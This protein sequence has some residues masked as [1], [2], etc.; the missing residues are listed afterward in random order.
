MMNKFSI[1]SSSLYLSLLS[2]FTWAETSTEV[3]Q[4]IQLQAETEGENLQQSTAMTK[5]SHDILDV[6]FSRSVLSKALI[7]QQDVQRI[8]DALT[9][10][11]GVYSQTNYGGGFWDNFSF[12]GFSTDPNI[13][14]QII[15][16]GLSVNRGLSAPRDMVNIESLDFLKGPMA[17]LY[18]RGEAGGLLNINTK[19]PEWERSSEVN[20]RA[21]SLEKYRASF[22]HTAPIS[23]AVAYRIAVAHED[24]QSFRDHVQSERWFFSPQLTWKISDSTQLDFDSEFTR[25]DGT[26]D[27]GVS[28]YQKQ[29][30]MDPKTFTGEPDDG[31]HIQKDHFYQ[32]RLAHQFN[33]D[34]KMN[35][36]LSVKD[37]QLK[38]F[39]SEPRRIQ[40]DG[41]TLERQRR[42]RDNKSDDILFQT[43]VLGTI[44]QDWAR[45]E[46]LLST[47]LGQMKY[48]QLQLRQ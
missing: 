43:E 32:L 20:L 19:K 25:Q 21:N 1:L 28:S 5:F 12:R 46:V 4:T 40:S 16:N 41:R 18:G 13:G 36:A 47:E 6:P 29:F 45:H 31:D 9:Q 14:A 37:T 23:D 24:N 10:V 22:E 42:Y 48:R 34:W 11:S 39:S 3:L 7:Q 35:N 38:G 44:Q 33:D 8:D 17:A 30:V 2:S 15:R 26:F 27:R